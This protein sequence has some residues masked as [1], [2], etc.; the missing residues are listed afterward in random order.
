MMGD[1]VDTQIS[2]NAMVLVCLGGEQEK[3]RKEGAQTRVQSAINNLNQSA[4]AWQISG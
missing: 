4:H 1:G 2:L 3:R